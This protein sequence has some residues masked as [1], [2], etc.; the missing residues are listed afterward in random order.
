MY[1]GLHVKRQLFLSDFNEIWIISKDFQKIIKYQISWKSVQWGP[2]YSIRT[3][4]RT[5]GIDEANSRFRNSAN[6]PK[7]N[8]GH[9]GFSVS[10]T[11]NKNTQVISCISNLFNIDISTAYARSFKQHFLTSGY[12]A[13]LSIAKITRR[14]TVIWWLIFVLW[15][16]P[17]GNRTDVLRR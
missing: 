15:Q 5:G 17:D 2:S 4:K 3:D 14:P 11:C 8:E 6:A 9:L 10:V 13:M 16:T 12:F 1:R 7:S